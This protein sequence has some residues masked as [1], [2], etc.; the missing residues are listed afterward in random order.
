MPDRKILNACEV[1]G[2]Q[3]QFLSFNQASMSI[4]K[5]S[6]L[7]E[8]EQIKDIAELWLQADLD[9]RDDRKVELEYVL[10]EALPHVR[11]ESLG[12]IRK[13]FRHVIHGSRQ[14]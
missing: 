10:A 8:L 7:R 4:K 2:Q 9:K 1:P 13:V 5:S 12:S 3:E 6:E 11:Q 14:V